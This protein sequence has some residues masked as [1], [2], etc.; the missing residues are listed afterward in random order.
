MAQWPHG[1]HQVQ[2]WEEAV[3]LTRWAA[4][5]RTPSSSVQGPGLLQAGGRPAATATCSAVV[6]LRSARLQ[7]ARAAGP[8]AQLRTAPSPRTRLGAEVHATGSDEDRRVMNTARAEVA[9]CRP[10]GPLTASLCRPQ[11]PAWTMENALRKQGSVPL[12]P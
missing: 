6:H 1:R 4:G 2:V 7:R 10:P 9:W 11:E 8:R 5:V 3:S 12:V